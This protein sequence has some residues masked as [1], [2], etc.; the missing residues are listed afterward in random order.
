MHNSPTH[1]TSS[2]KLQIACGTLLSAASAA[3]FLYGLGLWALSWPLPAR[4]MVG[5]LLI[6]LV[7]SG[8]RRDAQRRRRSAAS[9]VTTD[10][11]GREP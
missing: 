1:L 4:Y 9:T 5:G 10:D 3:A 6:N 7:S 11:G 8:W 2:T